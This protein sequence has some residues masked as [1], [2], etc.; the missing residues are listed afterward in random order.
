MKKVIIFCSKMTESK[1][2]KNFFENV[3]TKDYF[4]CIMK[5]L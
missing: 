4:K 2:T 1:I 3:L 5:T